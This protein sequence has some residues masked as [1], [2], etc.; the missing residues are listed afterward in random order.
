MAETQLKRRSAS[1][2]SVDFK[3]RIDMVHIYLQN[4]AKLCIKLSEISSGALLCMP[5]NNGFG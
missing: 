5:F 2:P 1:L 4:R 3:H